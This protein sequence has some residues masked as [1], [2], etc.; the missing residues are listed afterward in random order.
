MNRDIDHLEPEV[1]RKV[2]T[3]WS[4]EE[5]RAIARTELRRYG[6]ESYEPEVE[7]VRL[8]ILKLSEGALGELRRMTEAAKTDYRDVLMWAEYPEES[9]ALW[10]VNPNLTDEQRLLLKEIRARDRS[11][12][13]GWRRK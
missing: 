12:A 4:S 10:A 9:K 6:V 3:I 7:R 1:E 8:A 2:A 13:E 11:Q 5:E